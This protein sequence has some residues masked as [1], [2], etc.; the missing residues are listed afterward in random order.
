[1]KTMSLSSGWY[2]F[3]IIAVLSYLIGCINFAIIISK[4]KNHGEKDIRSIGSGN[5]GMLNMSRA[6]GMKIGVL[7]LFLDIMKGVV[8]CLTVKIIFKNIYYASNGI[9][10]QETAL[11]LAG[12]CA[13]MGHV[14][15]FW[16]KFKGGKGISTTIGVFLVAQ[17]LWTVIFGL[18]AIAFILL[19]NMGSMGSFIATTPSAIATCYSYYLKCVKNGVTLNWVFY[20]TQIIVSTI[21]VVTWWAHRVNISRLLNGEEHPTNWLQMIKNVKFKSKLKKEKNK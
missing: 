8:P 15:P 19:T 11:A 21:I 6:Y 5:P 1:M 20:V 13:V 10:L 2:W 3:L 7:I 16:L 9:S 17:P 18:S 4:F 14:F 12:F